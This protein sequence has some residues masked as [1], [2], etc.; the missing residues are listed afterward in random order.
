MTMKVRFY[1]ERGGRN[2]W[3]NEG[4][5][6]GEGAASC[7]DAYIEVEE[8]LLFITE[9]VAHRDHSEMVELATEIRSIV[10]AARG[11]RETS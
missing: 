1:C 11:S 6:K 7:D 3:V 10:A 4:T 2:E 5:C 8:L 9:P